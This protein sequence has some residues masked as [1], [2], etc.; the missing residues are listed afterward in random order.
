MLL[1]TIQLFFIFVITGLTL[2][3]P[4]S[5]ASVVGAHSAVLDFP[6]AGNAAPISIFDQ[7]GTL[8]E[9]FHP[10]DGIPGGGPGS[11][12]PTTTVGSISYNASTGELYSLVSGSGVNPSL[13]GIWKHSTDGT[14]SFVTP[15]ATYNPALG[16]TLA[17]TSVPEPS[18]L[19]LGAPALALHFGS[20]KR[21][22]AVAFREKVSGRLGRKPASAS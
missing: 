21:S 22:Q 13:A 12:L 9:T 7:S 17:A 6:V 11:Q 8:V 3:I 5:F 14:N 10:F 18:T 20:R 4:S 19:L 16:T 2:L 1:R 15:F